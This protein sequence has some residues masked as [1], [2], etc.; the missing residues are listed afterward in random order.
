MK[1][2]GPAAFA[3]AVGVLPVAATAQTAAQPSLQPPPPAVTALQATYDGA[4]AAYDKQD[5]DAAI[6]GFSKVLAALG[7]DDRSTAII[8]IRLADAL[9]AEERFHDAWAQAGRGIATLRTAATGP[10]DDL[11][12]GYETL[13]DILRLTL[14]YD[15]AISAYGQAKTF[16]AGDDK[17]TVVDLANIDIIQSAMVTHPDLA[18]STGDAMIADPRFATD[19]PAFQAQ[20]LSL[21]ARAELN[22]GDP[23]GARSYVD[24][25]LK[26]S[27]R[28][29]SPTFNLGLE[30]VRSD[31]ALVYAQLKNYGEV[32]RLLAASGAGRLPQQGWFVSAKM[33]SPVCGPDIGPDDTVVVEFSIGDDGRTGAA[34]PVYA[35]RP[36]PMGVEFARAVRTWHWTPQAVAGAGA[37]WRS[38]VRV[39]MRC[40]TSPPALALS[41]PFEQ[42][43][44]DWLRG[45]GMVADFSGHTPTRPSV[46][47][48]RADGPA[49]GIATLFW[50][51]GGERDPVRQRDEAAKLDALLVQAGAPIEARAL[52]AM[53]ASS[54]TVATNASVAEARARSLAAALQTFDQAAGGQRSAAWLRVE[55]AVAL[56]TTGDFSAAIA[57]LQAVVALPPTALAANDPIRTVAVLHLS[58]VEQK[59]GQPAAAVELQRLSGLT[60]QGCNL[61]DVRPVPTAMATNGNE[62]PPAA[63]QWGFEGWVKTGYDITADGKV[64]NA[65]ALVSYPP[66]VFDDAATKVAS[67]FR[68][69]LPTVGGSP[70][71]CSGESAAIAFVLPNR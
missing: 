46:A 25:A 58:L 63:Q 64:S 45:R 9:L 15:D 43:T 71:S 5:W 10:D 44:S 28:L 69:L 62:F 14:E 12:N 30:E 36:G 16:A 66:F 20:I 61:L 18:A 57:P 13:G 6:T 54:P 56:E 70:L 59:L 41:A 1:G 23:A 4:L 21:R 22:R 2:F 38:A 65:R 37:F 17:D 50:Q 27:G 11:A 55:M 8:R 32:R 24:Q 34:T 48:D 26:D 68:Y 33:D 29:D 39:Q 67:T 52:A 42:A 60:E 51:L 3:A 49:A 53:Y 7:T 35:S 31:A 40:E 47:G 19:A